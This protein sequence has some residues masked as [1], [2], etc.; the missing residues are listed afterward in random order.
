[1]VDNAVEFEEVTADGEL[2]IINECN[3]PDRFWTMHR[4]GG[5]AFVV[6]T[7]YRVQLYPS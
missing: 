3:D 1:M 4:G 6:L 7:K 2:L 5:G